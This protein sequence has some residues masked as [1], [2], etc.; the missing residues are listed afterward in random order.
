MFDRP[1]RVEGEDGLDDWLAMFAG[2]MIN[3]EISREVANR[4][5]PTMFRDGAWVLDYRRLRVVAKCNH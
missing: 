3:G 1:T 2:S 4:L 5:R